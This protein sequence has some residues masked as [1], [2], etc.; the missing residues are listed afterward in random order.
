M[1]KP[2]PYFIAAIL[3]ATAI[4]G[5]AAQNARDDRYPAATGTIP[6]VTAVPRTGAQTARQEWSGE[7]GASGH[8]L[9]TAEAI[10]AAG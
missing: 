3:L 9:M 1:R 10:R 6:P 4:G 2:R 8:P 7:S 5:A